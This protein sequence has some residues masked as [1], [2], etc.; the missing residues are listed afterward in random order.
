MKKEQ[1]SEKQKKYMEVKAIVDVMMG[2]AGL[3]ILS[4]VFLGIDA[5]NFVIF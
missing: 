5:A 4:P 2:A 3:V 1:L